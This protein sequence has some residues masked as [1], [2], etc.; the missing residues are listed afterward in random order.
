[1]QASRLERDTYELQPALFSQLTDDEA[2]RVGGGRWK[3]E[4]AVVQTPPPDNTVGSMSN[5]WGIN[6][7]GGVGTGPGV[8]GQCYLSPTCR[9]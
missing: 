2:T 5:A 7:P 9:L 1:M 8:Y 3:E 4:V 6:D